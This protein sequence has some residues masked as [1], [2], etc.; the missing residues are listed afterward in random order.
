MEGALTGCVVG[1]AFW[2]CIGAIVLVPM[3]LR[4]REDARFQKAI[5]GAYETGQ[6]VT[7]GFV[8][9]LAQGAWAGASLS[10]AEQDLRRAV[11]F[12]AAAMGTA[13]LAYGLSVGILVEGEISD[14]IN[15]ALAAGA[16]GILALIGLVH[17]AFWLFRRRTP[18][19]RGPGQGAA[20]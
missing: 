12:V 6:A 17:F 3:W 15:T 7:P 16:S 11:L 9:A 20:G 13:I 19:D 10:V 4:R 2:L 14:Y 1:A 18:A 8:E 5:Q